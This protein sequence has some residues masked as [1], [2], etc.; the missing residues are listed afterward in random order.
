MCEALPRWLLAQHLSWP[1]QAFKGGS[2]SRLSFPGSSLGTRMCEALP[3]WLLAQHLSWPY[4]A[5][6]KLLKKLLIDCLIWV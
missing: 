3:R 6:K 1:Y 5:F 2:A 4:Q